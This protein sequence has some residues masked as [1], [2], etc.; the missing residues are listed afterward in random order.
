VRG[1]VH[2]GETGLS[3][4]V[5]ADYDVVILDHVPPGY[6]GGTVAV[7]LREQGVS[8]PILLWHWAQSATKVRG[9]KQRR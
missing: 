5:G 6:D 1:V 8:T 9:L 3:Y 7:K 2:D 4:A